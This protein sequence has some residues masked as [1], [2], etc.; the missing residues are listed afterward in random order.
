MTVIADLLEPRPEVKNG[1]L[2]GVIHAYK[3]DESDSF[4]SDAQNFF[5]STYPSYAME[6]VFEKVDGKLNYEPSTGNIVLSGP[7]GS[8]KSHALVTL[9]HIFHHP[10]AANEWLKN[11]SIDLDVPSNSE[12]I[13]VS[14]QTV[15]PDF[16]W[17]PIFEKAGREDLL[18][19]VDKYPTIEVIQEL[20]GDKV[21]AI[22]LDE[23]GTWWRSIDSEK[24]D[25]I[26]RNQMFIQNLLEVAEDR[27]HQLFTF[28]TTYGTV[29]GLDKTLNRTDP[30]REDMSASGDKEKIIFHRLF[31]GKRSEV[32]GDKVKEVVQDYTRNYNPP[33]NIENLQR[34]EKKFINSYPFHPQLLSL[35][36]TI[37]EGAQ[38]RQDVRGE[39]TALANTI[40]SL[41]QETDAILLSDLNHRA[42]RGIDR[43]L[44]NKYEMDV[45][46][47]IEDIDY[48]ENLMMAILLHSFEEGMAATESDALLGAYKPSKEMTLTDLSM[49]LEN[50]HGTARYLHRSN[51]R[52]VIK[53]EVEIYAL[54]ERE[55]NDI[56]DDSARIEE[57]L[58]ALL[59]KEIFGKDIY[60]YEL[61][62]G[63]I[64]DRRD[65]NFVV[66]LSSYQNE[67]KLKKEL[68]DF[69]HGRQYQNSLV[70]IV[71]QHKHLMKDRKIKEKLKRIIASEN[72]L[73]GLEEGTEKVRQNLKEDRKEAIA[74]LKDYYGNWV[75]WVSR[76]E[77]KVDIRKIPV[78]PDMLE[79]RDEIKTDESQLKSYIRHTIDGEEGGVR[80]ERMIK[81][82]KRMRGLPFLSDESI[83]YSLLKKMNREDL[84]LQGDRGK[85]YDRVDP[86]GGIEPDWIVIDIDLTSPEEITETENEEEIKPGT[87][88][89]ND[90]VP[91]LTV[92]GTTEI[93]SK[94][95]QGNS[96]RSIS[97]KF[98]MSLNESKI[99][100]IN[101]VNLNL[102]FDKLDK[103]GLLELID[104]LPDCDYIETEI[105]VEESEED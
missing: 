71:P 94:K 14:A 2:E 52:Y 37:Y 72:L 45:Q 16:L 69:L 48:G 54:I 40:S 7:R 24:E 8:G 80:I 74:E 20:V 81:D 46:K 92:T 57:E 43:D 29:S 104:K 15:E 99:E 61:E 87:K 53:K 33:I 83:L 30:Y 19:K 38:D 58:K 41:Y 75:K 1:D 79:I 59:K 62:K 44:V 6:N 55:M 25:V 22:F 51:D 60:I 90:D 36:D 26:N 76:G 103:T 4:E 49:S 9:Y 82:L 12:S 102:K 89:E 70:F 5:E 95:A 18:K 97:N 13:I 63:E 68:E 50:L 10:N 101:E 88:I 105:E 39:M 96:P 78:E 31:E 34:Y 32:P 91:D 56:P 98:E 35:L 47:N 3:V 66:T 93:K 27:D 65:N 21:F 84:V 11:W 73:D 42:F 28:V 23:F 77:G 86:T 67:E 85:E 17:V 64:P 100:N